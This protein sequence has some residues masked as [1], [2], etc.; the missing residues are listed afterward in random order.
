MSCNIYVHSVHS[1]E[2]TRVFTYK[3]HVQITRRI[4]ELAVEY[5]RTNAMQNLRNF[6]DWMSMIERIEFTV[7]YDRTNPTNL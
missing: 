1:E 6:T 2:T 4:Y 3:Q 7:E 5:D